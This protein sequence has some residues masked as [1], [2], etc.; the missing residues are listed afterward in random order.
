MGRTVSPAGHGAA[1]GATLEAGRY[2]GARTR[3]VASRDV[4]ASEVLHEGARELPEHDHALA[5]FCM[6]VDGAYAEESGGRAIEYHSY[7]VG[8]HPAR[9]PHRDRV[10]ARGGRF[11][12]VEIAPGLIG[13][14]EV[15]L[16]PHLHALPGSVSLQMLRVLRALR[17]GTLSALDLESVA[18]ELCGEASTDRAIA[19]R[20][21][22]PW[23]ARLLA[24]LEETCS[25]PV[26]VRQLADRLGLHPVHVAREF[27]RRHGLTVGEYVN[28]LRVRAACR[29]IRTG[30]DSLSDVAHC[31][32]FADHA[33]FC[34]VFRR[35]LGC[36]PSAFAAAIR[37]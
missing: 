36:T 22:A 1:C 10:G 9:T 4:Q 8:F 34:R 29:A 32:G 16:R 18:W 5:Y 15:R 35:S 2:F 26:T 23:M 33:H 31:A 3:R 24:I 12:C 13:D 17:A 19:E 27:R 21:A 30:R 7:E 14:G 37:A 28:E 6:L 11:L 20:G 25:E